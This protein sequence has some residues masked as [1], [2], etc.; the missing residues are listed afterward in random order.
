MTIYCSFLL[1]F[2]YGI[3]TDGKNKNGGLT[4]KAV[5]FVHINTLGGYA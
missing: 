5:V 3:T 2:I 4:L 1:Y